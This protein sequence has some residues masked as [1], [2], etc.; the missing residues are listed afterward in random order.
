MILNLV[1]LLATFFSACTKQSATDTAL[2]PANIFNASGRSW[3][4]LGDSYTIGESVGVTDRYPAQ[5]A[6]LLKNDSIAIAEPQYIAR[7]GWTTI[8]LQSAIA[9][10]SLKPGYDIVSLL[11]G[12]NDQYQGMDTAG[13]RQRFTQLL[14]IAIGKAAG[15]LNH[16]FVLSIP[17]YGVTPFG[18]GSAKVSREI[19]AF[20]SI[21]KE[22]S[23]AFKVNYIDITPISR[24]AHTDQSLTATDQLHPSAKQYLRWAEL[25]RA[26]IKQS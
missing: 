1:I 23:L 11:I 12:V 22:I 4:A 17:D 24:E 2:P 6:L 15:R 5:T 8:D 21:N 25:L 9:A 16:V 10:A 13:Y 19:D 26:A 14:Q 20:N 3:L 18:G 7:T